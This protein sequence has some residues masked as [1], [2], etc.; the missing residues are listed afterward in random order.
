MGS[1]GSSNA[2]QRFRYKV[3]DPS[4]KP[5][6]P[7]PYKRSGSERSMGAFNIAHELTPKGIQKFVG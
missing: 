3:L 1:N 4:G 5:L 7:I 6:K 2:R